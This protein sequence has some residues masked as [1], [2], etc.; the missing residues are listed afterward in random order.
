MGTWVPRMRTAVLRASTHN[1]D[2]SSVPPWP[3]STA[4]ASLGEWVSHCWSLP[5]I[6]SSVSQASPALAA[7]IDELIAGR[8]TKARTARRI[9]TT[10]ARYIARARRR[11]TPF[12]LFA[13]C[14]TATFGS[15]AVW[16]WN[17]ILRARLRPDALWLAQIVQQLESSPNTLQYTSVQ[18]NNLIVVRGSQIIVPWQPHLSPGP[19]E[20]SDAE[21]WI[22]RVPEIDRVLH[23]A[24]TPVRAADLISDLD[25][26]CPQDP[27]KASEKLIA[28]LVATG[29][30]IT[31]LRPPGTTTEPL[32][33]IVE[34]LPDAQSGPL[35]QQLSTLDV[36]L[37]SP[38]HGSHDEVSHTVNAIAAQMRRLVSEATDSP[39]AVDVQV[40]AD[41]VLPE[42]IAADA[43]SA[44]AALIDVGP[45]ALSSWRTWRSAFL[46]RYGPGTPVPVLTAIDAVSGLG[47]PEHLT[48]SVSA[49]ITK[50]DEK[51]LDLAH[52]TV[53]EHQREIELD[54][55]LCTAL[56]EGQ[57]HRA[58]AGMVADLWLDVRAPS[59]AALDAGQYR[60][61]VVGFG[62][63]EAATGRFADL[64]G[65]T[66]DRTGHDGALVAQ[67]SAPPRD[68]RTENV[69]RTPQL[70]PYLVA[71]SEHRRPDPHTLGLNEL[72]V[73]SDA[74]QMYL[75]SL[76]HGRRVDVRLPHAGARHTMPAVARFVFELARHVHPPVTGFDWGAASR[77]AYLPRVTHGR[78]VLSPA[79]W[80][81]PFAG[82]ANW[83][84]MME[85]ARER[86]GIPQHVDIGTGDRRLRLDL[87]Q[88]MDREL[89]RDYARS[90]TR[91]MTVT[92]A[93]APSD[94]G[95][96]Q[97]R[98]H[99]VVVSVESHGFSQVAAPPVP[100]IH[101]AQSTSDV[102]YVR[103]A[104]P[105]E[106]HEEILTHYLHDLWD[107]WTDVP[108]WWFTR[109]R[110]ELRLRVRG[111]P[112]AAS[113]IIA[114]AEDLRRHG[115]TGPVT[116]D[117]HIPET[118]RYGSGSALAAV[119]NLFAHDSQAALA[120]LEHVRT[121]RD[122]NKQA[123]LAASLADFVVALAGDRETGMRWLIDHAQLARTSQPLD[124]RTRDQATE[125]CR[126]GPDARIAR[127]WRERA[128]AATTYATQLLSTEVR[129][130]SAFASLL[131][132]HHVRV[133]GI[134]ESEA[135]THKLARA[136]AL[137]HQSTGKA[138]P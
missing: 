79:R 111:T 59:L 41:L 122:V 64:L 16:A 75:V 136:V 29:V 97:G 115:L 126:S 105:A 135:V 114:W 138:S 33:H 88:A 63:P 17:P 11:A 30:L 1:I 125:I 20:N 103:L 37:R 65:I 50:R 69:L 93:P 82:E 85:E 84:R 116:V 110:S 102:V 81:L 6:A 130:T 49:S 46:D 54:T 43:A 109:S 76:R 68:L 51:L 96:C 90:V 113:R 78:S 123:L 133:A 7:R 28:T 10:L 124:R 99:E 127:A 23:L 38:I 74:E 101:L 120:I 22:Q 39:V 83:N 95:W 55:T 57:M 98:A 40:D 70:H 42:R 67:L 35:T 87:D 106:V 18:T 19:D 24:E 26:A 45:P 89:L 8:I 58:P 56:A 4:T 80:R 15:R 48:G 77:L 34:R 21:L 5:A 53:V 117:E 91:P 100:T 112:E 132:M 129:A 134:A 9:A 25:A 60:L 119:E 121:S 44:A 94:Y 32:Q 12:G 137:T 71:L 52:N 62:R 3:D 27:P 92:E 72:A 118:G 131:H 14:T 13:G 104:A 61:G 73:I 128:V 66:A 107:R 2:P 108:L 36:A 86:R 31:D 47:L